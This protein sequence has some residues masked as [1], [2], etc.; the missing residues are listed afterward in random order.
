[1]LT[2]FIIGISVLLQL[3]TVFFALRLIKVT[4]GI[5]AW[6]FISVA[7]VG[8]GARR[9]FSLI[10]IFLPPKSEKSSQIR[11]RNSQIWEP[12]YADSLGFV[13]T[14]SSRRVWCR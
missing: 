12:L 2:G 5:K 10:E 4:G 8:M 13:A 7:I 1:M 9:I 6:I 14:V 3:I 11:E